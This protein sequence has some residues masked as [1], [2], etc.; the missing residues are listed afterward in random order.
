MMELSDLR[1]FLAVVERGGITR[2]AE[3]LNRVQSSVTTRIK[4]LERDLGVDLFVREGK[5]L[6]LGS[7][8]HRLVP[9]AREILLSADRIREA[10]NEAHPS[11][12]LRL[13]AMESTAAIR[14]PGPLC[15][16]HDLY[17]AIS[18]ELFTGSPSEQI[19]RILSG[20]LD[21]GLVAEPVLDPRLDVLPVFT[22]KLVL[23]A[24]S[25]HPPI[26][27][28][29]DLRARTALAFHPGCPHRLRLEQWFADG[30]VPVERL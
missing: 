20:E 16:F 9:L 28:P 27:S 26:A 17:P 15:A 2:A 1:I 19:V 30:G 12:V 4:K 29:R 22:E 7:V 25:T 10:V 11:G 5:K 14:L 13:G 23:I 21:A 3:R 24:G 18:V 6:I 8:G